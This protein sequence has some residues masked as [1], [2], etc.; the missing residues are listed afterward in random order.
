MGKRRLVVLGLDGADWEIIGALVA[1][2]SLPN[3]AKMMRAGSH[4]NLRST[5]PPLT[6]PAWA[7]MFTGV[8]PGKHGIFD[9]ATLTEGK[10]RYTS[11]ADRL[12]PYFWDLMHNEKILAYNIPCSY[13]VRASGNTTLVSGYCTPGP[14]SE[15]ASPASVKE[16]ILKLVPDYEFNHGAESDLVRAGVADAKKK[17]Q[18]GIVRSLESRLKVST[19]LLAS[20]E[21]DAAFVVFSETDWIQHYFMHEFVAAE[22]KPETEVGRLYAPIDAFLGELLSRGY[23]VMVVSDHGFKLVKRMF[24]LNSV[25]IRDGFLHLKKGT[26]RHAMQSIGLTRDKIIS[27]LPRW[28]FYQIRKSEAFANLGRA[29]FP[30][31]ALMEGN[32]DFGRTEAYLFSNSGGMVLRDGAR[33][34]DIMRHVLGAED[35]SGKRP[36]G[37]VYQRESIYSGEAVPK[38]PHLVALSSGDNTLNV[39]LSARL[40]RPVDPKTEL[41]GYH[42]QFGIFLSMGPDLESRGKMEDLDLLDVAPTVM[43]FFGYPVPALMDGK[44]ID[45]LK[46]GA[47]A[48][49]GLKSGTL[50]AI[51]RLAGRRK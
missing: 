16:E 37:N 19:H 51:K 31:K 18:A 35:E 14:K 13:P 49:D 6:A 4:A 39:G 43:S 8:N 41:S 26:R 47:P 50:L 11:G 45:V 33:A 36:V 20:R 29:M 7:S 5:I 48:R 15:F 2:G 17:V 28:L 30:T 44:K 9:F 27:M 3:L 10:R 25:L 12:V 46:G 34:E 22:S 40:S 38:A 42:D 24:F 1:A 21:W 32:V 23:N